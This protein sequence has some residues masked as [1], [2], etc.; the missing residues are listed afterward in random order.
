[1]ENKNLKTISIETFIHLKGSTDTIF[2]NFK[3]LVDSNIICPNNIRFVSIKYEVMKGITDEAPVKMFFED[4]VA[5]FL[6]LTAGYSGS[7]PTTL[8]EIL[9][10]CFPE[11][12]EEMLSIDISTPREVVDSSYIKNSSTAYQFEYEGNYY[13]AM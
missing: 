2:N 8:K 6:D 5:V 1:M 7:G 12:N 13:Y 3:R 9:H 11:F 4:G 10:I